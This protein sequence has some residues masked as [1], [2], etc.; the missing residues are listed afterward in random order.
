ML[1]QFSRKPGKM[2][3]HGSVYLYGFRGII[4]GLDGSIKRNQV[5]VETKSR[6][7]SA[8]KCALRALSTLRPPLCR[9]L[10]PTLTWLPLNEL[11]SPDG[12]R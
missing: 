4:K 2:A 6:T 12:N 5:S 7:K 11:L 1:T 8:T 9:T 3:L 10:K